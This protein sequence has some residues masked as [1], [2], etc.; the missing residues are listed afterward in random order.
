MIRAVIFD[1]DGVLADTAA[2]HDIALND[3]LKSINPSYEITSEERMLEYGTLTTK[4]KIAKFFSKQGIYISP[5]EI[6]RLYTLKIEAVE[7][8]LDGVLASSNS[9]Q[10]VRDLRERG[11]K[12]AVCSNA[13][14]GF[15]RSV[16]KKLDIDEYFDVVLTNAFHGRHKPYPD[17]YL[18]AMLMMQVGPR[19]TVIFEDSYHGLKSAFDSGAH[20]F[21]VSSPAA[22]TR[23]FVAKQINR[24]ESFRNA[25]P[26]KT[27]NLTVVVPM[28]G[29]G[30]R[31]A[32]AGYKDHKPMIAVQNDTVLGLTLKSLA[33]IDAKFVFIVQKAH[34]DEYDL[35]T[36]LR[37]IKPGCEI[38][39][40]VGI[41]NEK[42]IIIVNLFFSQQNRTR[43]T[44]CQSV[45]LNDLTT[46]FYEPQSSSQIVFIIMRLLHNEYELSVNVCERLER[47]TQNR[48][49]L[50]SDHRLMIFVTSLRKS[51]T[52]TSHRH[53]NSKVVGL[54]GR[55]VA[56]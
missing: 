46:R 35:G 21:Q 10:V 36:R 13:G 30:S 18:K 38:V 45:N 4:N 54:N 23:D 3:V 7:R 15:V 26:I 2:I 27:D 49:V 42:V 47:Q 34:Y 51:R 20:V 19:E 33:N 1:L 24:S 32:K 53:H 43:G 6:D 9:F 28:A 37:L 22:L 39:Q 31:F 52:R 56:K 16:L 44:L 12:L 55:S 50:N 40:I 5:S 14:D 17:I 25:P 8:V 48:I 11:Y 29:S 41:D